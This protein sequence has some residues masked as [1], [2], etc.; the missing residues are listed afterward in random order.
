MPRQGGSRGY[1]E[2]YAGRH[3]KR[4]KALTSIPIDAATRENK[5]SS[6][7]H[8]RKRNERGVTHNA[9]TPLHFTRLARTTN[10]PKVHWRESHR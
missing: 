10:P 4:S 8:A 9:Q 5:L 3:A 2:S 6:E 7:R 1:S